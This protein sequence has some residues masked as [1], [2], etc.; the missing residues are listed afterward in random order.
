MKIFILSVVLG[1]K[2]MII[3][4]KMC[5]VNVRQMWKWK[6]HQ[7]HQDVRFI[8]CSKLLAKLL[9]W[10]SEGVEVSEVRVSVATHGLFFS[11]QCTLDLLILLQAAPANYSPFVV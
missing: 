5:D 1:D 6:Q 11:A 7:E 3:F 8:I 10:Q 2:Y 9:V 4:Y